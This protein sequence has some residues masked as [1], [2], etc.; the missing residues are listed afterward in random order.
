ML[1]KDYHV[2]QIRTGEKTVT[3]RDWA[4]GYHRPSEGD[5]RMV[6]TDFFQSHEECNCYIRVT[7]EPYKQPLGEMTDEDAQ[8]E[9]DYETLEEFKESWREI[10]G[11][12]NP[13]KVVD[14]VPFEYIGTS[15]PD[16][17]AQSE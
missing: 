7:D 12:W 11:E 16:V 4:D 3:R 14:V 15:R 1:F 6:Q 9:G 2:M 8:K 13:E 10:N 17:V 5:V